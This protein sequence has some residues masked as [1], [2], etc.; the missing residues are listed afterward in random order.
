MLSLLLSLLMLLAPAHP[1]GPVEPCKIYG[2]VYL[3]TEPSWRNRCYAVV[4]IEPEPAF[5]DVLVYHETSKLFADRAGLWFPAE[6][7]EFADYL[8]FVTT[9]R[10]RADF[11][12]SYTQVRSFAG[13][14]Q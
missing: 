11:V 3:E 5:A 7:R 6:Q 4:Y 8:L 14:K 2:S 12:I 13:C 1:A 10:S 9:D